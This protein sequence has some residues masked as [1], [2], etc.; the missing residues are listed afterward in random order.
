MIAEIQ[1]ALR[2]LAD[3]ANK[4]DDALKAKPDVYFGT[5]SSIDGSTANVII[6]GD[7]N[8]TPCAAQCT[9]QAGDRVT[10][11]RRGV[12]MVAISR[13]G[14]DSG[15]GGGSVAWG[16]I[17]GTLSNQTDLKNALDLKADSSSLAT[18]A[19]S[20]LYS[21]LSGTPTLAAVA[22]TGAYSDLSGTPT[23]A[24][25]ATSGSYSDLS[26]TPAI[27]NIPAGGTS[28]QV[29]SKASATDYDVGWVTPSGG[30][31][32]K[33]DLIYD[34][35]LYWWDSGAISGT[36][37]GS[38]DPSRA[39]MGYGELDAPITDYDFLVAHFKF[40][41]TTSLTN[42]CLTQTVA[43]GTIVQWMNTTQLETGKFQEFMYIFPAA[44]PSYYIDVGWG[45]TDATHVYA[46]RRAYSN[47]R[48]W[49]IDKIYGV[50][51]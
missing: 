18:V 26:N 27:H 29:L 14:G 6:D 40:G 2:L 46:K 16:G 41:D 30:G 20:G 48:Y 28:G 50:K 23:L 37:S 22:T 9:A 31:N 51:L 21:D 44:N 33:C 42:G 25:V 45:F 4:T 34:T 8:A 15:G 19:T 17:T 7:T 43:V 11:I 24:A 10:V 12:S 47:L 3:K 5:V 36:D 32:I 49:N 35:P 39:G 1:R 38:D 13:N